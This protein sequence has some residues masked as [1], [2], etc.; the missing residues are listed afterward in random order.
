[1]A[2]A[3][4]TEPDRPYTRRSFSPR[5]LQGRDWLARRFAEAGLTV[6][7]D[8]AGNLIGRLN[9]GGEGG[10]T[11]MIG[12]HSD[13][14]PSGGR[15]DGAA[16][17]IAALEVARSLGQ[18]GKPLRHALEVV[19]F[20]AEEP[21][22]YGLSCVG[23][24]AMSGRLTAEMQGYC[25]SAG[26]RLGAAIERMGGKPAGLG[27]KLRNDVAAFF[28]LHIEQ[29]IVLEKNAID[30]GVVS[31]I[32]GITRIEI[33][34]SGAAAH[35]GTTPME[36]RHDALTA[37][38]E[39]AVFVARRAGEIA[40]EG[41]GHFVATTGVLEVTP[42]AA[43]IV[44]KEARMIVDARAEQRATIEAFLQALDRE[45]AAAAARH[46]V[47]RTDFRLLSDT[48]PVLCDTR[49]RS[50]LDQ[51]A[52]AL[53]LSAM[54]LAS[55]AGHDAAFVAELAPVA[56]VFVPCRDGKSHTPEE[57]AE[58]DAIAAGA[59]VMLEAVRRFDG[60]A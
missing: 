19:D 15:F 1:M 22:E 42:N 5:F 28:E 36:L 33:V 39:T 31:G 13:T 18:S 38:A 43:N 59:A 41:T 26:E 37:A 17:V 48:M 44:P 21:S 6:S 30:I 25:N 11:I 55:G 46:R 57:W 4:I 40:K 3:E 10:R 47:E 12:S 54:P 35:A 20:L 2:L 9:G 34:F 52:Q 50:L 8:A 7:I 58:P 49:L 27:K 45:S 14:V 32:V 16:G 60:V 53:G 51:S 56:M 24:R 23:S 29:G